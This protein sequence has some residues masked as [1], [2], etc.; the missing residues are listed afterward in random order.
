ME[1]KS[2]VCSCRCDRCHLFWMFGVRR[3]TKQNKLLFSLDGNYAPQMISHSVLMARNP[4]KPCTIME[5]DWRTH[6]PGDLIINYRLSGKLGR[7]QISWI[8]VTS[9]T[10]WRLPDSGCW[11]CV[12]C[13]CRV[14]CQQVHSEKGLATTTDGA[15]LCQNTEEPSFIAVSPS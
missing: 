5:V 12:K 4:H 13:G 6:F 8:P 9:Q 2:K 3:W 15:H 1:W 7:V 14:W 11:W 10:D